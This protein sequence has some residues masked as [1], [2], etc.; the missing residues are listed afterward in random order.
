MMDADVERLA[1]VIDQLSIL[2]EGTEEEETLARLGV[3]GNGQQCSPQSRIFAPLLGAFDKPLVE[4]VVGRR[5][6][7]FPDVHRQT[8]DVVDQV[9]GMDPEE[10]GQEHSCRCGQVR[11]A[12]V[13]DLREIGLADFAAQLAIDS[14][15]DFSLGQFATQAA[16]RPFHDS[17]LSKLFTKR[18]CN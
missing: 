4:A 9:A 8:V 5:A 17:Q 7:M 11:P 12:S 13:L 3:L 6:Q 18:H 1:E 2:D 14:A 10:S 16:G 15:G